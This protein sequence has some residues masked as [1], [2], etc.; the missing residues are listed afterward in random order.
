MISRSPIRVVRLPALTVLAL[1]LGAG[2]VE[3]RLPDVLPKLS[4]ETV[5]AI[6]RPTGCMAKLEFSGKALIG[7]VIVDRL[8][9]PEDA[10]AEAVPAFKRDFEVPAAHRHRLRGR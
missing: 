5:E 7:A 10:E 2:G 1:M 8:C 3:A 6:H 9:L 4:I